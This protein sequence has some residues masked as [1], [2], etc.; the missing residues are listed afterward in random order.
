MLSRRRGDEAEAAIQG[1]SFDQA[2]FVCLKKCINNRPEFKEVGRT[3]RLIRVND[4]D[5]KE[6]GVRQRRLATSNELG[7]R[8]L[9][10][11]IVASAN[12]TDKPDRLATCRLCAYRH[13]DWGLSHS[14]SVTLQTRPSQ[15]IKPQ[16][17]VLVFIHSD[18]YHKCQVIKGPEPNDS[19]SYPVRPA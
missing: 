7:C 11:A 13:C 16:L 3:R 12:Q 2:K 4:D 18:T 14:G 10:Q 8:H 17:P 19:E 5:N 6:G 9:P 1:Y 15:G